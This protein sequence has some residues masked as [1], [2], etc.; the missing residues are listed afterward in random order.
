ILY[1]MATG[2]RA[3]QKKTAVDTLSAILNEEPE[4]IASS[5]P[6]TPAP[7][8]WIVERCLTKD[9]VS[10]YASTTDLARELATLKD[11]VSEASLA[12]GGAPARPRHAR[13]ALLL[14]AALL[15]ALWLGG[16]GS[17]PFWKA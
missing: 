7:L 8:R 4:P 16:F 6:Q 14:A 13:R 9:A 12:A 10:R 3:F 11:H 5:S 2:K 1:E 17:R 15:A